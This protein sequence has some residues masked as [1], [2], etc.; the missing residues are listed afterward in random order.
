MVK[1]VVLVRQRVGLLEPRRRTSSRGC[2]EDAP[3]TWASSR[4]SGCSC[5]STST[6]RSTTARSP[7]TPGSAPRCR[8]SRSCATAARALVLVSHL[9]R[10]K[11]REP[12]LSLRP[13]ADR[14]A[15]L[16]GADV[17]LAPAVV[18]D[19]VT[20][21]RRQP[22]RRR[23]AAAR[24]RPL[25]AGRD[26]ERPELAAALAALADVYV[27][28]AFGS[29]HRAH[30]STEG[31]ARLLPERAAGLLLE[32]EVTTLTGLLEDPDAAAGRG[33]RRRQGERQ[34]RRDR[35]LPARSPT[36]S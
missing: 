1:V 25:R 32:R 28:D 9:G 15:E 5:G 26:Q 30:A 27:N 31:V 8:R 33:A 17:T 18:G 10:P 22:R 6:S 7:T 21:V 19:D 3:R 2:C 13:V 20:G 24:E 34:D 35:A 23:R 12:E 29:A 4:A 14:L 11:D 36:R 16:T